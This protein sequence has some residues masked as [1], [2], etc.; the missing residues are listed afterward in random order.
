MGLAAFNRMRRKKAAEQAKGRQEK[1]D[2][3]KLNVNELKAALTERG[4]AFDEHAKKAE[5]QALL[6]A[7]V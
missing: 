4:I 6:E 1:P 5:L 2:A 7:A 3:K